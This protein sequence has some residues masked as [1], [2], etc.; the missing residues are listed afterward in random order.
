MAQFAWGEDV[1]GGSVGMNF[2]TPSTFAAI[3]IGG[4]FVEVLTTCNEVATR[5]E[6]A[7][8]QEKTVNARRA[9]DKLIFM[10]DWEPVFIRSDY[11]NAP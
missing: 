7:T 8:H 4:K 10:A 11:S 1:S 5:I 9:G 2:N 3:P 6:P